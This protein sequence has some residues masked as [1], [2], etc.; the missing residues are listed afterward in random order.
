MSVG[1]SNIDMNTLYTL[2]NQRALL[3]EQCSLEL[4]IHEQ[5][6]KAA[7]A[8]RKQNN[9]A[10]RHELETQL[11]AMDA[12]EEGLVNAE[13][14]AFLELRLSKVQQQQARPSKPRKTTSIRIKKP[15]VA[16]NMTR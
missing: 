3:E 6:L 13:D 14:L 11:A 8:Q 7:R 2:R 9:A 4:Q 12:E 16:K 15:E 1:S 5:K 10:R